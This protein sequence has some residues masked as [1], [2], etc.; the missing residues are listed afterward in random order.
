MAVDLETL[1]S[2]DVGDVDALDTFV[3]RCL[4]DAGVWP[5]PRTSDGIPD[6]QRMHADQP[7]PIRI[8]GRIYELEDQT[9]RVFWLELAHEARGA[10]LVRWTV[11]Y[12]QLPP[13]GRRARF[14]PSPPT[15]AEDATWRVVASGLAELE[16][17]ALRVVPGASRIVRVYD[18]AEPEG[19]R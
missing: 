18:D 2:R 14:P 7:G 17:A 1:F 8:R 6:A 16:G 15:H 11:Y 3:S 9:L 12:D 19:A 5:G 13:P 4:A 10:G